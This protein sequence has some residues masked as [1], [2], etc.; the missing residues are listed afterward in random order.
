MNEN[1]YNIN[2]VNNNGN[3]HDFNIQDY[4]D[5]IKFNNGNDNEDYYK[6]YLKDL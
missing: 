3:E 1:K 4:N 5:Y 6:N 2:I